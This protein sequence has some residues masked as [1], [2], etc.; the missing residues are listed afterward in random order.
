MSDGFRELLVLR[1]AKAQKDAGLR[2]YERA[3]NERG[4]QDAPQV[5]IWLRNH[6]LRPDRVVSSPALR[7]RQT[8]LF[9]VLPVGM[10]GDEIHWDEELYLADLQT[11]RD[12]IAATPGSVQRLLLVGHNPG[13][14]DLVLSLAGIEPG[15]PDNRLRTSALVHLAL[16]SDWR[17]LSPASA[18]LL[19]Y[20]RPAPP[21]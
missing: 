12:I 11:L 3:L 8:T 15:L 16:A 10:N 5:G 7:A 13:L 4:T 9:A 6:G 17:D 19:N 20:F 21:A 18:R 1:H 2:D 14:E